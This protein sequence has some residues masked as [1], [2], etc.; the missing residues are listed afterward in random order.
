MHK[1]DVLQTTETVTATYS[2]TIEWRSCRWCG[3]VEE[4]VVHER[5]VSATT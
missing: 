2:K 1:S 5:T 4:V 3:V